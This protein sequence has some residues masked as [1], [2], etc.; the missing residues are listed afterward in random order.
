MRSQGDA[1]NSSSRSCRCPCCIIICK[2]C[3][4]VGARDGDGKVC[5]LIRLK[6]GGIERR[7]GPDTRNSDQSCGARKIK[8]GFQL[9]P[10]I[11]MWKKLY[12]DRPVMHWGS[13]HYNFCLN[14]PSTHRPAGRSS[15]SFV[16]WCKNKNFSHRFSPKSA[17]LRLGMQV[18]FQK[19][20]I[21]L[22]SLQDKLNR[23]GQPARARWACGW[24]A[25]SKP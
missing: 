17:N 2:V 8:S 22:S 6:I 14:T 12:I 13:N 24:G 3:F 4:C 10:P 20:H 25:G 9:R 21:P 23:K 5:R 1:G 7:G 15:L 18:E 11:E 16:F 19:I